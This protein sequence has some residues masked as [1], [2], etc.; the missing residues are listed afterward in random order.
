MN[1]ATKR[2]NLTTKNDLAKVS[3]FG[4]KTKIANFTA[5]NRSLKTS[6]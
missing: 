4:I 5:L 6:L 1:F 2:L 3:I